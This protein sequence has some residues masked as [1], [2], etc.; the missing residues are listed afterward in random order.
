MQAS[1][2]FGSEIEHACRWPDPLHWNQL[3]VAQRARSRR[4][5]AMLR[6]AFGNHPRTLTLINAFS[7]GINLC[8]ADVGVNT[9]LQASNGFE[10]V[11]QL[12]LEYSIRTRSEALS[13]RTALA[14]K[15][16]A[17]HGNET[18]ASTIV[19]DTIRKIDFEMARYSKLLGTLSSRID[20]AG[21]HVAEADLV[22]V[23][24]RSLPDAVRTFCL[25]HTGGESYHAFRTTALRWEQQQRAFAEF[26][27]KKNL[28]QVNQV[29]VSD[30]STAHYDMSA[31]DGDGNWNL[32][33]VGGVKCGTCGSTKHG[34]NACDVV[35]LSKLRCFKCQKFGH[36][37]ANCP[38]RKK[39]KGDNK[40]VIKGKGKQKGKKG[41][42][43][44]KGFGKKGKMNEV[45]YEN[46]Y[47]GTDMW[48]QDD[49]SWWEDQSWLETSQVW[50]GSWDESWDY[51]W[52]EGPESWDESWSWPA[53]EDQQPNAGAASSTQGVQSLV[54]SPLISEVF[55]SVTTGLM[56]ETDSSN[57]SETVCSHF[58]CDETVFHVSVAGL[59]CLESNRLF[60]NCE[61]CM[62]V[63]DDFGANLEC[64]QLRN[65]RLNHFFNSLPPACF[66][67]APEFHEEPELIFVSD[68]ESA[69]SVVVDQ[70]TNFGDEFDDS[71]DDETETDMCQCGIWILDGC[72]NRPLK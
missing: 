24:L 54:L 5:L 52:N 40:Q 2:E 37:S 19:T 7:E 43:K 36:I 10:L 56:F 29:E 20:A 4:L 30:E 13:F 62:I 22:A 51:A 65:V 55:A 27:P 28:Y 61:N 64:C 49:G 58:L 47:D 26:H 12:T 16:F 3:N 60:C 72:M 50:N 71:S 34:T 9:E 67:F 68:S 17:L 39:G 53:I 32:D 70:P 42:G 59:Q 46:D 11:R 21:L 44:G 31:S 66:I 45:G 41:K 8:N 57:E 18:S 6:S 35:D 38:D 69:C 1:L 15:S 63:S 23:L 48:W 25:H 33:A 14:G